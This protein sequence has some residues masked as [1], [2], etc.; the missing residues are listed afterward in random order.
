MRFTDL[1]KATVLST[2]AVAVACGVAAIVGIAANGDRLLWVVGIGWW[3]VAT[4]G[5][6]IIG[7]QVQPSARIGKLLAEA[8][9]ATQIPQ[10]RPG[11]LLA[12]RLWPLGAVA[13]V[14]IGLASLLPQV[15]TI[16]TGYAIL[17]GLAWRRQSAA[18]TAVEERDGV[19][20]FVEAT[21]PFKPLKLV[22]TT[23]WIKS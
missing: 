19:S 22:R 16:T 14:A 2:C 5:G 13:I 6:M 1:L 12:G 18:V 23:G 17:W 21:S 11:S 10:Q 9:S 8:H 15:T 4:V 7:H 20:F 3:A